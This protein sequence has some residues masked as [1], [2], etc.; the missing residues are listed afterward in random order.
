LFALSWYYLWFHAIGKTIMPLVT[1]LHIER[2][3]VFGHVISRRVG[4]A[5]SRLSFQRPIA[6]E[7]PEAPL[8]PEAPPL[9]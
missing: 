3:T 6:P 2:S 8:P 5:V 4:R 7:E 9:A 1:L